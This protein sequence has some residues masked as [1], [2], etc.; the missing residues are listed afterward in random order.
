MS[1]SG[2]KLWRDNYWTNYAG[3]NTY[4]VQPGHY[5]MLGD[6]SAESADSRYWGLVPERLL[7]GPAVFIYL[8]TDC[9]F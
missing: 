8:P 2:L 1:V 9:T 6:N 5:F 7:I 3:N 4:F